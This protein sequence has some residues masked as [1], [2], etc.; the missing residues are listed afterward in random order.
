MLGRLQRPLGQLIDSGDL[1]AR[2]ERDGSG[3]PVLRFPCPGTTTTSGAVTGRGGTKSTV[4]RNA[5]SASRSASLGFG[6]CIVFVSEPRKAPG[7]DLILPLEQFPSWVAQNLPKEPRIYTKLRGKNLAVISEAAG[8]V[9]VV[10]GK[11]RDEL[12]RLR[13]IKGEAELRLMRKAADA[14]NAAHVA[15]M[16]ALNAAAA[17]PITPCPGH[18]IAAG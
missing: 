3:E 14:T 11:L 2:V 17:A 9:E 7:I 15:A 18:R 12:T 5:S 16:K 4:A 13:L 1:D 10:G 8:S 6:P